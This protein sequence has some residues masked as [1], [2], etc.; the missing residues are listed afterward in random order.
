MHLKNTAAELLNTAVLFVSSSYLRGASVGFVRAERTCIQ[1][2]AKISK[3]SFGTTVHMHDRQAE[4][5]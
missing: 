2:P 1:V 5:I 3:G 4:P